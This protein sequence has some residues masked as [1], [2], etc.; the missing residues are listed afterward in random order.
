MPR[1]R[2]LHARDIQARVEI[3]GPYSDATVAAAMDA[4]DLD[5][6]DLKALAGI[7]DVPGAAPRVRA[8]LADLEANIAAVAQKVGIPPDARDRFAAEVKLARGRY[9]LES[10]VDRQE[11]PAA[12][13]ATLQPAL[14]QTKQLL[15]LLQ[16]LPPEPRL[17]FGAAEAGLG[18]SIAAAEA[19]L[20]SL[21]SQATAGRP[22]ASAALHLRQGLRATFWECG[23]QCPHAR[24]PG[25]RGRKPARAR[26]CESCLNRWTTMALDVLGVAY[27][28][29]KKNP[30][31][32]RGG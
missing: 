15:D 14:V 9:L 4:R 29:P 19:E 27:P 10:L 8:E 11:H 7:A 5:S 32:F 20:A 30:R 1:P 23:P 31:R 13:I 2:R 26:C 24:A 17:P 16:S 21:H 3:F 25:R 6:C 22:P 28:D 12:V 18:E